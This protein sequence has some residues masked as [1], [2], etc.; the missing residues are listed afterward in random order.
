MFLYTYEAAALMPLKS[1]NAKKLSFVQSLTKK[2]EGQFAY[3]WLIEDLDLVDARNKLDVHRQ[4]AWRAIESVY[5]QAKEFG[6]SLEE[7]APKK[8]EDPFT[9]PH[10]VADKVEVALGRQLC[11]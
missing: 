3:F 1:I 9:T 11:A 8:P 10:G 4:V 5:R 6:F 7:L 2:V